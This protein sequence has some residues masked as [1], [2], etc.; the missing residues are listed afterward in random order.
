MSTLYQFPLIKGCTSKQNI[1][2][3]LSCMELTFCWGK[4]DD[5]KVDKQNILV[6][7]IISAKEKKNK[8]G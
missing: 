5:K 3:S 2:N 4:T 6:G 7:L 1:D 8:G